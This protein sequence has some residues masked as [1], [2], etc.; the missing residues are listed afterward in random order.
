MVRAKKVSGIDCQAPAL[1][2]IRLVLRQRF[3][4]MF[5]LRRAA[6]KWKDPEGVHSMRVASRRLRSASGDFL[7]YLN[8]RRVNSSLRQIKSLADGL[9]EVRDLDVAIMALEKLKSEVPTA[10]SKTLDDL[11]DSRKEKR[12]AA[13]KEL[14]SKLGRRRMEELAS[15]FETALT[16]ATTRLSQ[17][18]V[19]EA[20]IDV[21]R[22][23]IRER[24]QELETLSSSLY[25]P[26]HAEPLHE[27]RI[28]AKGLRYAIELFSDCWNPGLMGFAGETANLQIALGN[29]HDCD[30]WIARFEKEIYQTRK[31]KERDE[32]ETFV[33]LFT[34]FTQAR[35]KHFQEA[36]SIWNKWESEGFI[37]R[38][39]EVL[40]APVT[41][42][43][44]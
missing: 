2:G 42:E 26:T 9:G 20:Y 30:V 35:S 14:K 39:R 38:L 7:P 44:T 36:F 12:Q 23:V 18:S 25:R 27:M 31:R 33:W 17:G 34:Y 37:R 40:T 13:R 19:E 15:E 28:A 21:A 5:K 29:L 4:E 43:T 24:L 1:D 10:Y 41:P 22:T 3:D 16:A 32:G 11:I 8:K 6:L